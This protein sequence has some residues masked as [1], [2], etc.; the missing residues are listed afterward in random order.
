MCTIIV[1]NKYKEIGIRI[2]AWKICM[3]IENSCSI[4]TP[5][6]SNASIIQ[7]QSKST[8]NIEKMRTHN[9]MR[10][11]NGRKK[12]HPEVEIIDSKW[13][14]RF[15]R[16]SLPSVAYYLHVMFCHI[17]TVSLLVVGKQFPVHVHDV[18]VQKSI[19]SRDWLN[20]MKTIC[21]FF[22]F[23]SICLLWIEN[24]FWFFYKFY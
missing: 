23:V 1:R 5:I 24:E 10:M 4:Y 18:Y 14:F 6:F 15:I 11:E 9:H 8:W 19:K 16:Q 2:E 20:W 3:K 13:I 7:M 22:S 17:Y 12:K 21:N